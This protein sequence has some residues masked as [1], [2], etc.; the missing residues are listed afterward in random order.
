MESSSHKLAVL[1]CGDL[2]LAPDPDAAR[3]TDY[4]T[5]HVLGCSVA[6]VFTN[7]ILVHWLFYNKKELSVL[8][9]VVSTQSR[10]AFIGFNHVLGP[11]RFE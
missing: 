5:D 8:K 2:A 1:F 7:S 6:G 3:V 4:F 11:P 10:F 9:S